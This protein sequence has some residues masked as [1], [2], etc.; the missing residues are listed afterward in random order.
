M[1][2]ASLDFKGKGFI[3]YE[4][5]LQSLVVQRL[6]KGACQQGGRALK[7]AVEDV[8][9]FLQYFNLFPLKGGNRQKQTESGHEPLRGVMI[10]DTFKKTFFPHLH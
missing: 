4:D 8:Q 1:A 7:Y 3:T 10:F 6:L 9:L 5:F 2:Y